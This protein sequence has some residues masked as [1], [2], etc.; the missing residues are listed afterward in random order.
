LLAHRKRLRHAKSILN[1]LM[2]KYRYG[3][4]YTFNYKENPDYVGD[5]LVK[6]ENKGV[7][8]I[9]DPILASNF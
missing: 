7:D 2:I 8:L 6:T 4:D 9:F 3:A 5:I 1:I